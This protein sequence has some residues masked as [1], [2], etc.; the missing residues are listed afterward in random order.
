MGLL[1]TKKEKK[2]K[3]GKYALPENGHYVLKCKECSGEIHIPAHIE[4]EGL[5]FDFDP[6]RGKLTC[7]Y[8][9]Q[10]TYILDG[11]LWFFD[12]GVSEPANQTLHASFRDNMQLI[13]RHISVHH[14]T[15]YLMVSQG[16]TSGYYCYAKYKPNDCLTYRN[17]RVEGL[18]ELLE[19]VSIAGR[20]FDLSK[21]EIP[22]V[23]W[24]L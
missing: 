3:A 16:E 1:G 14:D 23:S 22:G 10:Y 4:H 18:D 17:G 7:A 5:V 9:G 19:T 6:K 12:V 21:A 2:T 20:R 11:V 8:E 24:P 13:H 15:F